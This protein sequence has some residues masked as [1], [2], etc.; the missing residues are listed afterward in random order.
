LLRRSLMKIV[1]VFVLFLDKE[2]SEYDDDALRRHANPA[3]LRSP[4]LDPVNR[5]RQC[6][7]GCLDVEVSFSTVGHPPTRHPQPLEDFPTTDIQ[8]ASVCATR[9]CAF[10]SNPG[11]LDPMEKPTIDSGNESIVATPAFFIGGGAPPAK[12][13]RIE[14]SSAPLHPGVPSWRTRS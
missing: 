13:Q 5:A 4:H 11:V 10:G 6:V 1:L 14:A 9:Q 3:C 8:K 12:L 7:S 2:P